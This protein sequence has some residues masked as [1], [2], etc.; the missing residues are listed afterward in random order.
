MHRRRVVGRAQA[1]GERGRKAAGVRKQGVSCPYPK[2]LKVLKYMSRRA[3]WTRCSTQVLLPSVSQDMFLLQWVYKD[4][5]YSLYLRLPGLCQS[6]YDEWSKRAFV[7]YLVFTSLDDLAQIWFSTDIDENWYKHN[8]IFLHHSTR[9]LL[10]TWV[11]ALLQDDHIRR[12]KKPEEG[13][14]R[15]LEPI[16]DRLDSWKMGMV[17][18]AQLNCENPGLFNTSSKSLLHTS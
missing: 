11:L 5:H 17:S 7:E 15:A 4:T 12:L 14:E 18:D 16:R 13:F 6:N 8:P 3:R 1:K 2:Y 10:D 9:P